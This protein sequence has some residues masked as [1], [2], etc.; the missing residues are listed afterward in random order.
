MKD[1]KLKMELSIHMIAAMRMNVVQHH[2][3]LYH[4]QDLLQPHAHDVNAR[5]Q[6]V[7]I[8]FDRMRQF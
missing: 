1:Q 5:H 3:S 2:Q 7:R 8:Q 4:E 6:P